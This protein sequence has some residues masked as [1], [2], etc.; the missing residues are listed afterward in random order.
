[1]HLPKAFFKLPRR[2]DTE[3]LRAEVAAM[4]ADAWVPHPNGISGNSSVRL[5]SADGGENDRVD[6]DMRATRHLA[7]AP[8]MRQLLASFGVAWS[9]TRLLRLAPGAGVPAHADINYHWFYRVRLHIPVITR[10]EVRFHCDGA[11]VH[12]AAG[13]GWV[14]DNWRLH[15]VVNPTPDERIH[16]VA[17]TAGNAAFW[18]LVGSSEDTDVQSASLVYDPRADGRVLTERNVQRPVMNPAELELLVGNLRGELLAQGE[19]VDSRLRLA[20]YHGLLDAFVRDWRHLYLLHGEDPAGRAEFVRLRDTVRLASRT[21]ADGLVLRTNRVASHQVLEGRVLRVC[22]GV[23]SSRPEAGDGEYRPAPPPPPVI[24]PIAAPAAVPAAAPAAASAAASAAAPAAAPRAAVEG[25]LNRPIFVVAAP[26]SGSTLL[27]ETLAASEQIATLGGE[28]HWLIETIAELC[29]GAPGVNS[30]RLVAANAPPHVAD[31][32]RSQILERLIDR[33]GARL[34]DGRVLRF[35]E[36][37]PKN[38]VRIPFLQRLFPDALF[39][40][41]WREP[42]GNLSS[43]IEAWRSG[44]WRTYPRLEGFVQPWSLLLPPGWETLRGRPLEEIAAFQWHSTNRI[45]LDDLAAVPAGH[46]TA[47]SY[48][49]LTTD[50]AAAIRRLCRFAGIDF[51]LALAER[52]DQPLPPAQH[53]L[54]PADPEKW[55]R[56]EAAIERVLPS[57]EATWRDLQAIGAEEQPALTHAPK[58]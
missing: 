7:H 16:L 21:L 29:P 24:Q 40:F 34:V 25:C 3:Q 45:M 23:E 9:R 47:I 11:S 41:L 18:Q 44:K 13:E 55:R 57:L 42:R 43:I 46:W 52:L 22:L 58:R 8:Y 5:I 33:R 20:R 19:T 53:T 27:F 28:A 10:E 51:D 17:D 1:M 12:M 48:A 6:G 4:P 14:F 31:R 26:R 35:L 50:P 30:N 54:T 37:T 38:A 49:E 36:K 56:N 39:V 32:I 2:F 15:H